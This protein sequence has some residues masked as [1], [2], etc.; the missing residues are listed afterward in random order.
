MCL[1]FVKIVHES[2]VGAYDNTEEYRAQ[3]SRLGDP[4]YAQPDL[5]DINARI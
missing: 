1:I 2:Q 3:H 5:Y 4:F